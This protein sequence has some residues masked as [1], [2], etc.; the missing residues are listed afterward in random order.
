[1]FPPRCIQ[2]PCMNIE[3]KSWTM[4]PLE[5]VYAQRP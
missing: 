5:G 2:P 1:M 3:L 4:P